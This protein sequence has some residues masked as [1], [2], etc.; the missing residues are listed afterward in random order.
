MKKF[1]APLL[2][3]TLS[4]GVSA[5]AFALTPTDQYG[6]AVMSNAAQRTVVVNDKT[7]FINVKHGETVTIRDGENSV[8]WTFDGTGGAFDL[9]KILPAA[10][11]GHAIEVYV[12]PETRA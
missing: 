6:S 4:A 10:G 2:I 5:S 9:S 11:A 8:S 12:E 3:A 1:F 7:R